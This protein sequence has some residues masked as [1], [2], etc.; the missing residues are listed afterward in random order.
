MDLSTQ[1]KKRRDA[2]EDPL[3]RLSGLI[4]KLEQV[5]TRMDAAVKVWPQIGRTLQPAQQLLQS[6][7]N[8]MRSLKKAI[9]HLWHEGFEVNWKE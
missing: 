5:H 7:L 4:D 1:A 2:V 8:D 3:F 9:A 6:I